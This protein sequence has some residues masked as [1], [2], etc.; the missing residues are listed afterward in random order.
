MSEI[1]E[2]KMGREYKSHSEMR[3]KWKKKLFYNLKGR[4][5]LA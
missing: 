5:H 1:G 4:D 3:N 2:E